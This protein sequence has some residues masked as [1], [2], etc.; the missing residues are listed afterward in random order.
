[1]DL[2][3]SPLGVAVRDAIAD[4]LNTCTP[5][6]EPLSLGMAVRHVFLKVPDCAMTEKQIADLVAE[7]A[8]DGGYN[9]HFDVRY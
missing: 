9:V 2:E 3:T 7:Q 1:M 5:Y 6:D 4:F 8:V